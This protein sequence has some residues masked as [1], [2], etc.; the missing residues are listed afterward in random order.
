MGPV[1][2]GLMRV[3]PPCGRN[4]LPMIEGAGLPGS[5]HPEA[6]PRGEVWADAGAGAQGAW[7]G[8]RGGTVGTGV[9]GRCRLARG[10]HRY[11][12]NGIHRQSPLGWTARTHTRVASPSAT[13]RGA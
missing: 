2:L 10:V 5:Q 8:A 6:L 3:G 12:T 13:L 4:R 1:A 11:D 7:G 9:G